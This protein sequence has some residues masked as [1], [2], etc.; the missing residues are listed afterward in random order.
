[1]VLS[2]SLY[3]SLMVLSEFANGPLTVPLWASGGFRLSLGPL[4]V[5]MELLNSPLVVNSSK[6]FY[7]GLAPGK[8]MVFL[9]SGSKMVLLR[10]SNGPLV[11]PNGT[12]ILLFSRGL[13]M[14]PSFSYNFFEINYFLSYAVPSVSIVH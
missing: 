3:G 9:Y 4:V 12:V 2:Y 14:I 10:L 5:F 8:F 6:W 7:R 1:M 11:V 13:L